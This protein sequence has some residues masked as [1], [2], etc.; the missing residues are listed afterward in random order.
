MKIF[1]KY[2]QASYH[3]TKKSK[4]IQAHFHLK[5]KLFIRKILQKYTEKKNYVKLLL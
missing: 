3:E 4:N 1:R 5:Y 2:F